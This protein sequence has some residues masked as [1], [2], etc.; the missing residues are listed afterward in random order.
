M[1]IYEID[2]QMHAQRAFIIVY[3]YTVTVNWLTLLLYEWPFVFHT[4]M[5]IIMSR[6]FHQ[7]GK[8][9]IWKYFIQHAISHN[10]A[11]M[12]FLC[13]TLNLMKPAYTGITCVCVC[14]CAHPLHIQQIQPWC[15]NN[16]F[17]KNK[18][19]IYKKNDKLF[20]LCVMAMFAILTL[21]I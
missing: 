8:Q 19:I 9:I 3:T 1:N 11:H 4:K 10:L 15:I 5:K 21:L 2:T 13:N 16:Y 6:R 17:F 20:K 14:V 12:G 7:S 18:L